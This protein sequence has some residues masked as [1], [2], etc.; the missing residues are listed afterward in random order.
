MS[1]RPGFFDKFMQQLRA[2]NA[3]IPAKLFDDLIKRAES[4][5]RDEPPPKIALI[6]ESGVGKSSTINALFNAGADVGHQEATTRKEQEVGV[7]FEPV[8]GQKGALLVYDM[9]GLGESLATREMHLATYERVLR[10]VDVALWILDA[11]YRAMESVQRFLLE[12]ISSINSDLVVRMVF[13][14]N[15]AD[16]IHPG[17]WIA[18]ANLP[19]E[20]QEEN[21]SGRIANVQHLIREAIPMWRG[22][23]VAYSAVK[24]YNLPR[25]FSVMLNAV[26]K[27]RRWVIAEQ[28][29]IADFLDLVDPRLLSEDPRKIAAQSTSQSRDAR[30]A[31]DKAV[32]SMSDREIEELARFLED[33]RRRRDK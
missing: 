11:Q 22:E 17:D 33:Q 5:I 19:S 16:L 7:P 2:E 29:A 26:S 30:T 14:L 23:V 31:V 10:E 3:G 4:R 20:E 18:F 1:A 13:A 27:R 24:R 9:P 12:N 21:L 15:K 32:D 28:R 25:L 6:G 8:Q